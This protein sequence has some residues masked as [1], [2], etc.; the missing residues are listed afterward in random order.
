ML[1]F[2]LSE[3]FAAVIVLSGEVFEADF[4]ATFLS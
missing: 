4:K 3:D 1:S 2:L